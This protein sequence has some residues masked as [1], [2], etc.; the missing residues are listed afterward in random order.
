MFRMSSLAAA[1]LLSALAFALP[2]EAETTVESSKGTT[3]AVAPVA[4]FNEPW[5][6]TFLPDGS[7][8]VTEKSGTLLHVAA[9]GQEK[10]P[11][12]GTPAV[13]YGGQGGLGD[14][15]L[16]PNFAEN[17]LVYLTFAEEG[18]GGQGAAVARARLAVDDGER[19]RLENVA[20]IWRQVPKVSGMGHYSHRIAFGPDGMMFVTSGERQK[21]TPAQAMDSNLGKIVRLHDDGAVPSD[22]PFQS[23]GEMARQFW[24]I[25]HRNMLGLAFD[26]GGQL[27]AHEMGPRGGDELN[28]IEKGA[29]Y[30][31]PNVSNGENYDGSP[32]PDHATSDAYTKPEISWTPV[33]APAGFV[34]YD[35]DLF[36]DWKGDGLIGGLRS[37]ALV[38]VAFED[39]GQGG[40]ATEVERFDMGQRVREVEQGPDGAL[41]VLEDGPGGRLLKLTPASTA[42]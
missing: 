10:T 39:G 24:T 12:A 11:V 7:M 42:K 32:I 14:V 36:A 8:L 26:G 29:N 23:D 16:H 25:G 40:T 37:Q 18:E 13:A 27:W 20:V 41:F 17:R 19:P 9:D 38:H 5:A 1:P 35:G 4:E 22:N 30:G 31:W 6:M 33:I 21:K 34:I 28:R 3:I 15:V 2:A